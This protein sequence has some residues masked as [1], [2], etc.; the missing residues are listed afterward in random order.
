[1]VHSVK[2]IQ[3]KVLRDLG[4]KLPEGLLILCRNFHSMKLHIHPHNTYDTDA[5][6]E[7]MERHF[8]AEKVRECC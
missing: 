1:M 3:S 4:I 2:R 7:L 5:L 8:L 6:K